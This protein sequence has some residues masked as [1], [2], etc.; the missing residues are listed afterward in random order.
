MSGRLFKSLRL[1]PHKRTRTAT[2]TTAD[3]DNDKDSDGEI[4]ARTTLPL[5]RFPS[6]TDLSP[7]HREVSAL[8]NPSPLSSLSN[9]GG[10]P[11]PRCCAHKMNKL[12]IISQRGIHSSSGWHLTS[13]RDGMI[14]LPFSSEILGFFG[15]IPCTWFPSVSAEK[16]EGM[17]DPTLIDG[18]IWRFL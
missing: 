14:E 13:D 7:L 6:T 8:A 3:A 16:I 1:G 12:H 15:V 17:R 10:G 11:P 2:A 18:T 4:A 9:R 5:L